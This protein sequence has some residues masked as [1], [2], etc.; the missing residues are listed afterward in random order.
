MNF[1][2]NFF[3]VALPAGTA[4]TFE[5]IFQRV[6]ALPVSDER[7]VEI[8]R[9]PVR[10]QSGVIA[11]NSYCGDMIRIRM[12]DV[13]VKAS[14]S[15]PVEL[16]EF[17]EDEG[18]GEETAFLYQPQFS[19]LILQR[20]RHG[21]S[22]AMLARY[23][24][25]KGGLDGP[26]LFEP[27]MQLQ[28]YQRMMR[29]EVVRKLQLELASAQN[30]NLF[31]EMGYGIS[32]MV[33]LLSETNA[34]YARLTISMGRER[35]SM[36]VAPIRRIIQQAFDLHST[37]QNQVLKIEMTASDNEGEP[38][39]VIDLLKDR[40]TVSYPVLESERHFDFEARLWYLRQA[41]DDKSAELHQIFHNV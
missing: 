14:I 29:K 20:N 7:N 3:R 16:V 30:P 4:T 40:M 19:V 13:P 39:E 17:D 33:D 10:L 32:G 18:L 21:I 31:R 41:L 6:D 15:G 2:A 12:D 37:N 28:A 24:E 5:E 22:P 26:L 8:Y 9:Q 35:G 1:S 11:G 23:F 38:C 25:R 36:Y 34:P 27:I